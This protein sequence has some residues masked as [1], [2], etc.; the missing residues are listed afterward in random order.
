MMDVF[1]EGGATGGCLSVLLAARALASV[2][3]SVLFLQSAIDKM[4]D[5]SGNLE[6]LTGHFASSPLSGVVPAM[7]TTVTLLELAAGL[8]SGAG[9]VMLLAGGSAALAIWGALL[10]AVSLLAL[11]FGQRL[12]KDYEGAAVLAG[13]FLLVLFTLYL[14]SI[15]GPGPGV[16]A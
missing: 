13:Y 5:R 6:W 11:F 4:S 9:A 10:S 14:Y 12:A 8:A 2:F 3:L 7:L 1:C 16:S 15:Q